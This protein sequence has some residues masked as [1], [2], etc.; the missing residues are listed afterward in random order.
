MYYFSGERKWTH[1]KGHRKAKRVKSLKFLGSPMSWPYLSSFCKFWNLD[2]FG[3]VVRFV[4]IWK[5]V[6][7]GKTRFINFSIRISV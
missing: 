5:N 7:L 2:F 6:I 3:I 4:S 1:G